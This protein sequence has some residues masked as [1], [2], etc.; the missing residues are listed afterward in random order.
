MEGIFH[1]GGF[2]KTRASWYTLGGEDETGGGIGDEGGR[3]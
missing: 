2:L 1:R 3:S